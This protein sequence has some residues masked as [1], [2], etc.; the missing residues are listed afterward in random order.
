MTAFRRKCFPS[1]GKY[2]H[3]HTLS[4]SLSLS[5]FQSN[6]RTLFMYVSLSICRFVSHYLPTSLY[7]RFSGSF[8]WWKLFFLYV[9]AYLEVFT[10]LNLFLPSSLSLYLFNRPFC[11]SVW[12]CLFSSCHN[13]QHNYQRC[14]G[15]KLVT[16]SVESYIPTYCTHCW[17]ATSYFL[18]LFLSTVSFYLSVCLS[19]LDSASSSRYTY[20]PASTFYSFPFIKSTRRLSFK[21]RFIFAAN[22]WNW[23]GENLVKMIRRVG[24]SCCSHCCRC[25]HCHCQHVNIRRQRY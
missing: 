4:L 24:W 8:L 19:Y 16:S 10:I 15:F 14:T 9:C 2:S 22:D 6:I 18:I 12:L 5:L 17:A 20:T 3:T 13:R 23:K 7:V 1:A 21:I 25:H 11:V